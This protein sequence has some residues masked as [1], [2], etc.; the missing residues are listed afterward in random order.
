LPKLLFA[1]SDADFDK[2]YDKFIKDRDQL[3]YEKVRT[4]EQTKYELN[5]KRLQKT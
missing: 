5:L 4:Y 3:G 1:K 2:L